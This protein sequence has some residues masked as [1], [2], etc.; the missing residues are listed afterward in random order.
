MKVNNL[1][2][3]LFEMILNMMILERRKTLKTIP[4]R[5]MK[6]KNLQKPPIAMLQNVMM[7]N[8]SLQENKKI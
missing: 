3:P 6:V 1:Q 5:S 2:N 4:S 8:I 7:L